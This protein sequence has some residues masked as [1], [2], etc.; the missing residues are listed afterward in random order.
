MTDAPRP[1]ATFPTTRITLVEAACGSGTDARGALSALCTA[2]W[3]PI[4]AFVRRLGYA[5]EDAEDLTQG[6]FS[7]LLEKQ[8]LRDFRRERGRF[9]SFLLAAAKHFIANEYDRARAGKR[10]GSHA[11]VPLDDLLR[12]AESRYSLEP[13]HDLTPERA[14]DRQWALALLARV[15]AQ[16]RAEALQAGNELQFT[17]LSSCLSPGDRDVGYRELAVEWQTTEGAIKVAVHRLRQRF[18]TLLRDEISHTVLDPD[19]VGDE[20]RYLL[21]ALRRDL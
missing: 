11:A 19:E 7:R 16:L 4:Y 21:A 9:R 3:Y 12:T 6:F 2:Y 17:R 5:Q 15:E 18:R 14:F 20:L 1:R 13:R 8:Y 10:G